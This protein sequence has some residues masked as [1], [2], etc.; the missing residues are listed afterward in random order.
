MCVMMRLFIAAA[1]GGPRVAV[2]GAIF[3][4]SLRQVES[5]LTLGWEMGWAT[6]Q[7]VDQFDW[8]SP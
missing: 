5:F 3:L 8:S 7:I 1:S 2:G 6:A 4:L